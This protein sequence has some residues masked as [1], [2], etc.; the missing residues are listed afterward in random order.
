MIENVILYAKNTLGFDMCITSRFIFPVI[1]GK[2]L[3]FLWVDFLLPDC[4]WVICNYIIKGFTFL[5]TTE[6][7]KMITWWLFDNDLLF[8]Y[9][10]SF[11]PY[12]ITS[13]GNDLR[14]LPVGITVRKYLEERIFFFMIWKEIFAVTEK[15][16]T[17]NSC[18]EMDSKL[19]I[20]EG[21]LNHRFMI[22]IN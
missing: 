17:Q 20:R 16:W 5:I 10:R 1:T 15:H 19:H 13:S 7:M 9:F 21:K 2:I 8:Y 6:S 18:N 11:S 12:G 22:L 14:V 3:S 4:S